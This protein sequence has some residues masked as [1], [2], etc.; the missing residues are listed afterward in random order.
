LQGML[1]RLGIFSNSGAKSNAKWRV[2]FNISGE[3]VASGNSR[4]EALDN[5]R[6]MIRDHPDTF[7]ASGNFKVLDKPEGA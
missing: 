5:A 6:K 4:S 3:V 7:V 1:K 2:S